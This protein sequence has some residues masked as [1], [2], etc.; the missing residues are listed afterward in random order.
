MVHHDPDYL[1][2]GDDFEGV[3]AWG[4]IAN[5]SYLRCLHGGPAYGRWTDHGCHAATAYAPLNRI[6]SSSTCWRRFRSR[7][8]GRAGT[9]VNQFERLA[10]GHGF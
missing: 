3:L 2:L 7:V 4:M 1:S 6:A 10:S 5:R 9:G 8:R